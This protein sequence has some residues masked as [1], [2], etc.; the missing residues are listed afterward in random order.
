MAFSLITGR[1]D[2][3][4]VT[5]DDMGTLFALTK[6]DGRYRLDDI[7]CSVIDA[8]TV[9]VSAGNLLIDGRHFRNSSEG[10]NLTIAN[11]SQGMNRI[12]AIVVEY[13]YETVGEDYL[14]RGQL[15]VVQGTPVA[16]T[17]EVPDCEVGSILN[18]DQL[19]RVL[20]FTVPI[21]GIS[22]G[23]PSECLLDEYELPAKYGGTGVAVELVHEVR[24]AVADAVAAAAA[25]NAAAQRSAMI[26][27][28]A[29]TQDELAQLAAAL[30]SVTGGYMV[31]GDTVF[32]PS[33]KGVATNDEI[34]FYSAS[35]NE[36]TGVITLT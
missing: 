27:E 24:G 16:G 12:D 18:N 20:L 23:T 35:F 8:N 17:P 9:H 7:V 15:V 14:E 2:H 28:G 4:H 31:A 21:D 19:V 5:S 32:V 26:A 6:G 3:D 1:D 22:V 36:E 33:S 11:G 13:D 25:A 10:E 34:T 29:V 30:V